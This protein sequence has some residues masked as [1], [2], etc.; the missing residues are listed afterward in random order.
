VLNAGDFFGEMELLGIGTEPAEIHALTPVRILS[1]PAS[2][3]TQLLDEHPQIAVG[4]REIAHERL[5]TGGS[6]ARS[7]VVERAIDSGVVRGSKVLARVP[8]LCPPGCRLCERACGDRHG[9]PRIRL[10]DTTFGTFDVPGGCRHCSWSPE[11]VEA[12]PEDAIQYGESGFLVVNESCTGCGACVEGCPHDA[13]SMIPLY[14]PV[15]GALEWM[16]RHV[17]QPQPIRFD[18]NKCDGCYGYSDQACLSICPTGSLRW[19]N[20]DELYDAE[21]EPVP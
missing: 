8:A 11:C 19:V 17:R 14:P 10:N 9:A 15:S 20:A 5:R 18:A 21:L 1:L 12:C 7:D 16:L 13:I 6:P 4:M 3:F 2:T